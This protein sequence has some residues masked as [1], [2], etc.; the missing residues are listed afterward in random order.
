M[1]TFDNQRKAEG[2]VRAK[3]YVGGVKLT[4]WATIIDLNVVTRG[5]DNKEW[6]AA[7]PSG[8]MSLTVANE[9]AAERFAPGQEWFVTLSPAPVGQEGMGESA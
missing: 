3:M 9:V 5:E 7:T 2:S 8:N 4:P 6:A 1:A